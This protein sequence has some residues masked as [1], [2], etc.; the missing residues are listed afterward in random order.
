ML[1][2]EILVQLKGT[3]AVEEQE[4]FKVFYDMENVGVGWN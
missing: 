4:Q 3:K 2:S 1:K